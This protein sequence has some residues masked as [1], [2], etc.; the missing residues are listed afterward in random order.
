MAKAKKKHRTGARI[1]CVITF[2]DRSK[3]KLEAKG[4]PEV[5]ILRL[6]PKLIDVIVAGR[7]DQ[8]AAFL[9]ALGLD[10]EK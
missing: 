6:I 9:E 4:S 7:V 5:S 1:E 8:R 3:M 2:N 10:E